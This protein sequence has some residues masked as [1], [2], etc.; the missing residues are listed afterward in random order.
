[1]RIGFATPSNSAVNALINNFTADQYIGIGW[2]GRLAERIISSWSWQPDMSAVTVTLRPNLKFHDH[3]PVDLQT[4]RQALE[5]SLKAPQT[6]GTNVTFKSVAGVELV[7]DEQGKLVHNQLRVKLSRPEAFFLD[8]LAN[9]TLRKPSADKDADL[10]GTGPYQPESADGIVKLTA[11]KEYYR[12]TPRIAGLEIH[13]FAEPRAA[14]AALMRDEIDVVHEMMESA[15]PPGQN[16]VRAYPFVRP[17]YYQLLFNVRHPILKNPAVRQALSYG[18][19]RQA[20]I[21]HALAG[22]GTVAEGPIWPYH[23]AYSTAQKVYTHNSDSATLRL[24]STG[25]KV[26]KASQPGQ[27]PSR[28]RLRCL[29]LANNAQ[30]E[31]IALILQKQF[32]EIGVDLAIE[33]EAA[34]TLV[35]RLNKGD[36][37][38]VLG[39]RTSGRS[40]AWTYLSFHSSQ[41]PGGYSAADTVLESL[42]RTTAEPAV[43]AAVSD[44][45]QIMHDDPP[46]IF[47]AWPKVARVVSTKFAVPD[48]GSERAAGR[49]VFSSIY[50]WHPA[51]ASRP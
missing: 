3:S 5:A 1:M 16:T 13:R 37:D 21:E 33:T 49:D 24:D 2:N 9:Q 6:P 25:L 26:K 46:A 30:F 43:R 10:I 7:H 41:S 31:K 23:W 47:I 44:L 40:L 35:A 12:G 18:V 48:E 19:D 42:R 29:I 15:V 28:L 8:D 17:Y 36:F 51:S 45:Q 50:L 20:I 39:P 14:W 22:Q 11:F 34:D 4:F 38:T 27:M 32:Y